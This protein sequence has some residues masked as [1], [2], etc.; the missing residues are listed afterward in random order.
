MP[1][2]SNQSRP[3]FPE[4]LDATMLRVFRAC[5]HQFFLSHGLGL[6]PKTISIHLHAGKCFARGMEVYRKTFYSGQRSHDQSLT[7][8]VTA[9]IRE[10]ADFDLF[11]DDQKSLWNICLAVEAAFV[12]WPAELD[13]IQPFMVRGEPAVE[14]N[15]VQALPGTAHPITGNPLLYTGR[16]DMLGEYNGQLFGE[17]DKTAKSLGGQWSKQFELR[18]QFT[19]YVWGAQ[20]FGYPVAGMVIRGVGLLKTKIT[21]QQ[22]LQYRPVWMIERWLEQTR[23]DIA[24]MIQCWESG[25][26]DYNLDESCAAYGGCPYLKLCTV[27]NPENWIESEYRVDFWNPLEVSGAKL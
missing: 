22:S 24:R 1:S 4:V 2:P 3:A 26:W 20:A 5:P 10:W 17:D 16:F 19:G 14:F 9:V 27:P 12:E 11:E 13:Y 8:A 23:R 18:S 6:K 25:L 21:F 15:F 7:A